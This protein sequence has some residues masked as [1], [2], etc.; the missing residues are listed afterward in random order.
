MPE[1]NPL[2]HIYTYSHHSR[3]YGQN[4][5]ATSESGKDL[6]KAE[7]ADIVFNALLENYAGIGETLTFLKE[8]PGAN[9]GQ[10]KEML[11]EKCNLNWNHRDSLKGVCYG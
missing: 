5:L 3:S 2:R 7:K 6:L 11:K 1:W 8:S 4:G 10:I 9:S